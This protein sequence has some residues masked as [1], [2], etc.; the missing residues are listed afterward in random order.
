MSSS[1]RNICCTKWNAI[2]S[3][4]LKAK[5]N[6]HSDELNGGDTATISSNTSRNTDTTTTA[7]ATTSTATATTR[8]GSLM[9]AT[10]REGKVPYGETSRK[11]RRTTFTYDDWVSH[12]NTDKQITTNIRGM[13]F[14]GIIRQLQE[15][16]ALVSAVAFF[17][18]LWNELLLGPLLEMPLSLEM[19]MPLSLSLSLPRLA[20]PA[21]PFTLS[22]PALGLLLV[23]KTNASYARWLEARNTWAKIVSQARNI[24]RMSRTFTFD[25]NGS[26]GSIDNNGIMNISTGVTTMQDLSDSVWLLCRCLMNDLSDPSDEEEFQNEVR[27]TFIV[28]SQSSQSLTSTSTS[29]QSTST[30]TSTSTSLSEHQRQHLVTNIIQSTDRT[31]AALTHTSRMLDNMPIDEKRRVEIDK[32]L[33]IIGDCISVCE[34]IYSSPVPLVYTRHTGR[35][36]SVWM[37]LL[38]TALYDSFHSFVVG[39]GNAADAADAASTIGSTVDTASYITALLNDLQCLAII[40]ATA[41]IGLFLFGI[42]ELAIQLEEPFSILPMQKFCD[43]VRKSA[44]TVNEWSLPQLLSSPTPP[45]P[46]PPPQ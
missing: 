15:E 17:V 32:S 1:P 40:P 41:I 42:D 18:V 24:V 26:N 31:M 20:L 37:I 4:A 44:R 13:F 16:I 2:S 19:E 21:L 3:Q 8:P 11:Y 9:E 29:T 28:P 23:F 33:V 35:F 38:P 36:L 45:T 6:D 25:N 5:N 12:R 10:I 30:S 14:S 34:K 43:D 22:S 7:T 27:D 46:P 39:G